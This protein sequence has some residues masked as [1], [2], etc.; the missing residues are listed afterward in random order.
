MSY[1]ANRTIII[2]LRYRDWKEHRLAC[3]LSID[4]TD[5]SLGFDDLGILS[6]PETFRPYREGDLSGPNKKT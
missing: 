2:H 4:F 1:L 3:G 5:D 6:V